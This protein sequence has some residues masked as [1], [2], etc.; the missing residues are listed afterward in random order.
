MKNLAS[1]SGLRVPGGIAARI[2]RPVVLSILVLFSFAAAYAEDRVLVTHVV[3]FANAND[4]ATTK[5]II[6]PTTS[7]ITVP[8]PC[9]DGQTSCPRI[10]DAVAPHAVIRTAAWPRAGV[11]VE[12]L[13]LDSRLL[14]YVEIE[15]PLKTIVRIGSLPLVTGARFYDLPDPATSGR[16]AFVFVAAPKGEERTF[17]SIDDGLGSRRAVKLEG[18]A[19]EPLYGAGA[20]LH[21]GYGPGYPQLPAPSGIYTFAL[22]VHDATGA[23]T[24]ASPVE[25]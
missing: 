19:V 4:Y 17:V 7:A 15:T 20:R 23:I 24:V 1:F 8:R 5:V 21:L 3:P 16:E 9:P 13:H 11:G 14:V 6:N 22:I 2:W 12:T 10:V 18:A 25:E